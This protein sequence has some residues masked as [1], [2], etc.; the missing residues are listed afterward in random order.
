MKKIVELKKAPPEADP[1]SELE[2]LRARCDGYEA[3]VSQL[4]ALL[5]EARDQRI[6]LE[7]SNAYLDSEWKKLRAEL[8]E[9]NL[10]L[11]DFA[12]RNE[13]LVEKLERLTKP[14]SKSGPGGE[15]R[16]FPKRDD[17]QETPRTPV[18]AAKPRAEPDSLVGT[19][20]LDSWEADPNSLVGKRRPNPW[21]KPA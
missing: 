12:K 18:V 1:A 15:R 13:R 4:D 10:G 11:A 16:G 7:E 20:A 14:G 9:K 3:R 5:T 17:R 19:R 2:E 21:E 6:L 8:N